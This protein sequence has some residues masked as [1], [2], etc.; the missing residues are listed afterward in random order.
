[1]PYLSPQAK[2]PGACSR[3]IPPSGGVAG[4]ARRSS[5]ATTRGW[6][7]AWPTRPRASWPWRRR[8]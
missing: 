1:M 7:A 3:L 6:N 5:F 8:I 4:W 2:P